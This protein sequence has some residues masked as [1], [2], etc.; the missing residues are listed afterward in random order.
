LLLTTGL[1]VSIH[2]EFAVHEEE[3]PSGSLLRFAF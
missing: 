1:C 2:S 3:G